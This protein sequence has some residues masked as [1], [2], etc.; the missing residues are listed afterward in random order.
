V[1][2]KIRESWRD[3]ERE[4]ADEARLTGMMRLSREPPAPKKA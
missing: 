4:Q 2:A 1:A 3:A